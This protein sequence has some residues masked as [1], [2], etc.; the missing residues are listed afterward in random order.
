MRR[1][2]GGGTMDIGIPP[3]PKG[4]RAGLEAGGGGPRLAY[5]ITLSA[6]DEAAPFGISRGGHTAL[7][8]RGKALAS[9]WRE[10]GEAREG[11]EPDAV[12]IGSRRLEGI[13]FLRS[14]S[15]ADLGGIVRF[16]KVISALRLAQ[17]GKTA[18]ARGAA[19]SR[20]A[21][22]AKG[23]DAKGPG[24]TAAGGSGRASAPLWK[25]GYAGK[26]LRGSAALAEARKAIASRQ[27]R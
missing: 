4:K 11:V 23:S 13:L 16:L 27:A 9:L 22:G 20:G 26:P 15:G 5:R 3:Q 1:D 8:A 6:R 21:K 7:N 2:R 14:K 18:A 17:L 12:A 19:A 10:L 24:E 25:Q